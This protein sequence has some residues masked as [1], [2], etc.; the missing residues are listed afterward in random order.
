[1]K[2]KTATALIVIAALAVITASQTF[3]IVPQA[4]QALVLQFGKPVAQHKEPGLKLKI[5]VI[6][7]VVRFDR[8]VLNVD[9]QA[10]EVILADQKRL[11]VD[12]FAR[13]R[14]IDMLQFHQTLRTETEASTRLRNLL[15]SSLR[16]NLGNVSLADILSD[17]RSTIMNTIRTQ[18]NSE[19]RR[20]GLE[21]V[22]VRIGRA[23]LPEQTSQAI[24]ARMRSE[25]EREAAEFRA[26]G[27]ELAQQI[28]AKAD[29]E[30]TILLAEA[31]KGA[32]TLRGQGDEQA[33][34]VYGQAF[35]RD[36]EFYRFYRSMEAYRLSLG[37]KSDTTLVLTPEGDFF[38][39]FQNLKGGR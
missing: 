36:P 7:N 17:K 24:Y 31:E 30:R 22:D 6:H 14:I 15:S 38:K 27:Q 12:T 37:G 33:I 18:V 16:S 5:P 21:I 34:R 3:F 29:K 32:Q 11:V 8:R 35:K 23:D 13:Y 28:R 20:L 9:P 26:Q 39:Y 10:E 25:R 1:M 19:V 4:Q 2:Q